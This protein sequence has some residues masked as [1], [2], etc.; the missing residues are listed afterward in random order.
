MN[1]LLLLVIAAVVLVALAVVLGKVAEAADARRR[2]GWAIA[3]L[4]VAGV[5]SAWSATRRSRR[6]TPAARS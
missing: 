4:P 3:G 6:N 5:H 1:P 2:E